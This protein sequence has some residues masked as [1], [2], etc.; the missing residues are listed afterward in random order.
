M[1]F[2][3]GISTT[4][5]ERGDFPALPV[6]N[7]LA[8]PVST[9]PGTALQ[10]RPGLEYND[11]EM[12]SGPVRGLYTADNVLGSAVFGVSGSEL[13][14]GPTLLGTIDGDGPVSFDGYEDYV[15]INAGDSIWKYDGTVLSSVA[16]PD[17]ASVSKIVVAGSRLIAI[18]ADTGTFYWTEPLGIV[19]DPLDFA[20]AENQPD[21]IKDVLYVGDKLV[22]FGSETIEYW[23]ITDDADLPFA[24]L[25]GATL[26]VGIKETGAAVEFSRTFAWVTNFNEVCVGSPENIISEPELQVRIAASSSTQLWVFYVDDNEYLAVRLDN[27]TWVYG[28]RSQAWAKFESYGQTN[29]LPRCYDDGYFGLN[30]GGTLAQWSD[31]YADFDGPHERSFRAWSAITS[32]SVVVANIILRTN[33]GTTPFLTGTYSEPVV[34]LR[35]SKNGGRSWHPWKSRRLGIQGQYRIKTFWS[36]MG[37]FGYPGLLAEIRVTDPVPFRVSGLVL[38]EPFGGA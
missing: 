35:T 27:E 30:N 11:T 31:G 37:Q 9:E 8:E 5:R 25:V 33:P 34:E 22:L 29:W 23:P 10:S 17:D 24:P 26:P 21:V 13:Y 18:R 16:F 38:N 36:S 32:E 20:T 28:A 4:E 6:V 15:F 1:D 14:E 19:I 12:G 3:Y 2:V 7:M